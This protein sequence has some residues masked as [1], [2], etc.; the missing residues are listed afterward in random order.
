MR[1]DIPNTN[2]SIRESEAGSEQPEVHVDKW[3]WERQREATK[4]VILKTQLG[5]EGERMLKTK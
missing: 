4:A 1:E 5:E 3:G 2:K